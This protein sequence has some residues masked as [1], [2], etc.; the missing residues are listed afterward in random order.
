[1]SYNKCRATWL[2]VARLA[3]SIFPLDENDAAKRRDLTCSLTDR[4]FITYAVHRRGNFFSR[5]IC[6]FMAMVERKKKKK[7]KDIGH[8]QS[9]EIN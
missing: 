2:R 8:A 4:I 5:K 1:M 7:K 3:I 6:P 9:P